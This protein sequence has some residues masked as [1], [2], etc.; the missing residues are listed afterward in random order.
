VNV[1]Q[2]LGAG[3]GGV[4]PNLAV[5][6]P[7]GALMA[8]DMATAWLAH[9]AR[10]GTRITLRVTP[11]A[12]HSRLVAEGENLRAHVTAPPEKGKANAEVQKLLAAALGLPKSRLRLV[13]GATGRDK[14]FEI[15]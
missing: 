6:A 14:V 15:A 12:A 9:L 13:R 8:G 1:L 3:A 2:H 7:A 10:P 11:R 4:N 5:V